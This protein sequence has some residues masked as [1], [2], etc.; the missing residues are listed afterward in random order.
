MSVLSAQWRGGSTF[1]EQLIFT[2]AS[3]QIFL[4]DE[5]A[6]ACNALMKARALAHGRVLPDS[7]RPA[8]AD[9]NLEALNCDFESF[10]ITALY[11][12]QQLR[13]QL[14]SLHQ[15]QYQSSTSLWRACNSTP[16]ALRALK[17]V[18]MIGSLRHFLR[19]C[20]KKGLHNVRVLQLVRHP[21][22]VL[23]S[24]LAVL[25]A[26][27]TFT[28]SAYQLKSMDW[29]PSHL[30]DRPDLNISKLC[31]MMLKDVRNV[32]EMQRRMEPAMLVHYDELLLDPAGTARRVHL[33]LNVQTD[34]Q[35]LLSFIAKHV[36]EYSKHRK[37]IKPA[38]D[39][40]STVREA[41]VA[42]R[43]SNAA[44]VTQQPASCAQL[45]RLVA[46]LRDC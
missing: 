24:R 46:P 33:F 31:S 26:G 23:R 3:K 28:S 15:L 11:Q 39:T 41:T 38:A 19:G 18:R 2:T 45:L 20:R 35:A 8:V 37:S 29:L 43:C 7:V 12:W 32:H 21:Y 44:P 40:Y 9:A 27:V 1:A 10:N 22:S 30:H 16:F 4:L 5:P 6:F 13:G 14:S 25:Q 34:E 36:R 42:S 17:T